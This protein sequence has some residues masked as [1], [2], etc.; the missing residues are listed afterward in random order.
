MK[1]VGNMSKA[2][3]DRGLI[4]NQTN[5]RSAQQVNLFGEQSFDAQFDR[6]LIL[7]HFGFQLTTQ[8]RTVVH[9]KNFTVDVPRPLGAKENDGPGYVFRRGHAP[10]GS[11]ILDRF[12][13]ARVSEDIRAHVSV[14]PSWGD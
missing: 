13:K 3:I 7:R 14:D 10:D 2:V 6:L 8:N 5:A 12:S 9:V 11:R 4:A 1:N